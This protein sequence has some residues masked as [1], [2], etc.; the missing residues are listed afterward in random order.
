MEKRFFVYILSNCTNVATYV[1]VTSNLP[2]RIYEHKQ[3][4]DP[5]SFTAKY[6]ITKL[7]Y[8]EDAGTDPIIAFEREKQI[9]KWR[10]SKKNDLVATMNPEWND[11]YNGLL[12]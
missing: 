11:L 1:G 10:R 6:N 3:H 12:E 2:A 5:D 7:V 8:Y 4:M 9:K